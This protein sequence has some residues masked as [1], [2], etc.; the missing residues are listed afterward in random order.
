MFIF[1]DESGNFAKH[2][3]ERFF[4][5]GSMVV[6]NQRFTDKGIRK[7]FKSKFPRK[8]R[9]QN[10]IKWSS[11]GITPE[12]RLKTLRYIAS[13]GVGIRFG[14]LLRQNIPLSFRGKNNTVDTGILYTNIV[15]EVLK[16]YLPSAQSEIYIFC[17]ERPLKGMTR[18]Q[19]EKSII[20]ELLPFCPPQTRIQIEMIDSTANGNMQI[21]DW[22]SGALRAYLEGLP[23][24]ND[25]FSALSGSLLQD[26]KEF[27]T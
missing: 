2:A 17:D 21:V 7:W 22:I 24:G 3:N 6:D 18:Q 25:Y 16:S 4:V 26:G 11:N 15:G 12:L 8:M 14:F 9:N 19:F 23:C 10:E 1:L 20:N 13:M 27:F 5:I